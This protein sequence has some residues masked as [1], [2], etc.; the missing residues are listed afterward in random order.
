MNPATTRPFVA[1]YRVS[2]Q[3]Q[4]RSGLGLDAQRHAVTGYLDSSGGRLLHEFTEVETGKGSNALARRPQ[5]RAALDHCKRHKACLLI[6][7]VDRLA[8]NTHFV[9]GLM[10]TGVD[11]V[12]ADMP[13]ATKV[14]LSIY[15]CMSE[16][17][18]DQISERTKAALAAAKKRGV[19]L[20]TTGP[21]N[22]RRKNDERQAAALAFADR[23]RPLFMSFQDRGLTQRQMAAELTRMKVTT[24]AGRDRWNLRG[25]QRV[26]ELLKAPV[27]VATDHPDAG[28][29]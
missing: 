6:A 20:G 12:A 21:T 13:N 14:M 2:T 23:L 15:A 19:R 27:P 28:T 18:R 16:W 8:R 3:R 29:W 10:E 11:F 22:L 25:V 4:G 9:T 5:L 17:E 7:K 26:L 24:P 1:Y